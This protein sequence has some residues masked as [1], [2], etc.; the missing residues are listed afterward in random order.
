MR[1]RSAVPGSCT[2]AL[3]SREGAHCLALLYQLE[4]SE[5]WP[6]DRMR[7]TQNAQVLQIMNHAVHHSPFYS[8]RLKT[9]PLRSWDDN[10]W[11]Q[12]PI[13]RR[14][15]LQTAGRQLFCTALPEGHE[16]RGQVSTSGSTGRPVTILRTSVTEQISVA[17]VLR[18][19]VWHERDH[20]G[21]AAV[22]RFLSKPNEPFPPRGRRLNSWGRPQSFVTKTGPA[23]ALDPTVTPVHVQAEI[24]RDFDPKYLLSYPSNIRDLA[25]F[26]RDKGLAFSDLED[27]TTIGEP[28]P[29]GLHDLAR[30]TWGAAIADIY[31]CQ[32]MGYLALQCPEN[33]HYHVQSENVLLEVV[34]DDGLPCKPGEVG[35]V[36][37]TSL[38]NF[39]SP[40][41][42]YE[43]GDLAEVGEPC[44]CGRRLPVLK[45]IVGRERQMF[46]FP[47]GSKRWPGIWVASIPQHTGVKFSQI[48]VVQTHLDR[49][50]IRIVPIG[51]LGENERQRIAAYFRQS[52]MFDFQCSFE[53]LDEIPRSTGGKYEDFR[54][55]VKT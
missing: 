10:A 7:E 50:L 32:E 54:C 28:L 52:L 45:R 1:F 31:T 29:E 43:V 5:K 49:L 51:A 19:D 16:F 17:F 30:D 47:D 15:E 20:S 42:R 22:S 23:L 11:R 38:H 24:I 33:G 35:R 12:L 13:L 55:E 44:S 14:E 48:Q 39:A 36:L 40:L 26:C 41:I 46:V 18:D 4:R 2:L 6:E 34:R 27:I 53:T 37:L 8:R 3:P 21:R 25:Q 9:Y